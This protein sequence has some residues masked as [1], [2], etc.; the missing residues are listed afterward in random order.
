LRQAA[1]RRSAHLNCGRSVRSARNTV[2]GVNRSQPGRSPR[3]PYE[4]STADDLLRRHARRA[5][6]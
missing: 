1:E 3:E 6:C 4:T 5:T 2:S